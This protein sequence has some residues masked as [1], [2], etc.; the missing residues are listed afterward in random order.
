MNTSSINERYSHDHDRLDQ[1]FA[2]FQSFKRSEPAKAKEMFNEFRAGLERHIIWEEEILFPSF[3]KKF[4]HLGR[5]TEVMRW[6]HREIRKFLETIARKLAEG[7]C[8]T[9]MDEMG[10]QAVLCPHNHKE[11]NIL[12][13]M[14]DRITADEERTE[15]FNKMDAG[16]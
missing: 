8:D 11:E 4:G 1:L 2:R 16:A 5:P 13:P 9:G 10:L 15:I 14:I 3:E 12:Y 6:E 7:D